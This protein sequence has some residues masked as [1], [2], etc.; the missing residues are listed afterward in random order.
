MTGPN[1]IPWRVVYAKAVL[2]VIVAVVGVVLPIDFLLA[3]DGYLIFLRPAEL[4]PVWGLAWLFY[5]AFGLVLGTLAVFG[6]TVLAVLLRRAPRPL[7]LGAATWLALSLV[8]IAVIRAVK[9]WI[10]IHFVSIDEWL[11]VHQYWIAAVVF[12]ACAVAASRDFAERRIAERLMRWSAACGLLVTV[13]APLFCIV[14]GLR[15]AAPKFSAVASPSTAAHPDIILVTADA[16][17]ANHASFLGYARPTTPN[18]ETLGRQADVFVHYYSNSNF[19]T[20]SVNS[21]IDGVRP[22][23]HRANQFLTKISPQVADSSLVARLRKSGYETCAVW[24]NSLASPFLNSCDRWLDKSVFATTHLSG[25]DISSVMCTRFSHFPP[26]TELGAF[27]IT[28]KVADRL[29]IALGIWSMTDQ[30]A[31]EPAFSR[32]RELIESRDPSRPL[33]LWVH[34]MRPHNPYAAPAP[35]LGEFNKGP[36]MRTRYDSSP[37][38][39]FFSSKADDEKNEDFKGRYDEALAYFD[40]SVGE[41]VGWLKARGSFD[42]SLLIVSSDHGESF[43]HRYGIHAGPMLYEDVIHVPLLIKEPGE[44]AGRRIEALSEQIDLMPTILELS[45]V[46][47]EGPVEGRSLIPAINGQAMDRPVFSMNFEQNSRFKDLNTG[48]VA[49]IDGRWKYVRFL[50]HLHGPL[51]PKLEDAL[52]NLQSDPGE[53]VNLASVEPAVA[54]AMRSAIDEQVR[55]HVKPPQ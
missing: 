15:P 12:A 29:A 48:T 6:A 30:N 41:F 10:G 38:G 22:W 2:I 53:T 20:A 8:A 45:G 5:A 47:V 52:Y 46:G 19:T 36:M 25:P 27:V 23:T 7:I 49:M 37:I 4:V 14:A 17:A 50:G 35:F 40:S 28:T 39:E 42:K 3:V 9:L 43:S 55:L 54:A 33:F 13:I 31:L 21:F 11:G 1:L 16:F 24:T 34:L 26:V 44:T 18:L 32:A 51:I